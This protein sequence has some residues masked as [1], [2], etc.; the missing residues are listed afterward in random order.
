MI[1]MNVTKATR[2]ASIMLL[3]ALS[4][5]GAMVQKAKADEANQLTSFTFSGPVEVP[6]RVLSAGTYVFKVLDVSGQRD[7]VQVTNK[8][9]DKVYGTFI[10]IPDLRMKR[11]GKTVITFTE[12]AEGSPEAIK[13]WF[14]PG[15]SYGHEFVYP[16]SKAVQ[17]AKANNL[18]VPS[19]PDEMTPQ[20]A[21]P[22]S[23]V[24]ADSVVAMKQTALKAQKPNEEEVEVAEVFEVPPAPGGAAGELPKTA[25][26]MPLV[27]LSGLLLI[28]LAFSLRLTAA[29]I[30][31]AAR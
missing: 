7:I 6:G 18:P 5:V 8:R 14:Y 24:N 1:E 11:T 30:N 25:S 12:R 10:T 21:M 26:Q 13:G 19:M 28:G 3:V 16:K 29:K 31:S 20:T 22:A 27:G 17:L 23:N 15:D 9:G 2:T 4:T